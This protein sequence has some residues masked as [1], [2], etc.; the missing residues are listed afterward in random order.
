MIL[1][2]TARRF[3]SWLL[4]VALNLAVVAASASYAAAAD[5]SANGTRLWDFRYPNR[6]AAHEMTM[7]D[8]VMLSD[9]S[10]AI[11]AMGD[12]W[13]GSLGLYRLGPDGGFRGRQEL[14]G[15]RGW[16]T[17][18][19]MPAIALVDGVGGSPGYIVVGSH[20]GYGRL[21]LGS[22]P[23]ADF[24][25][26]ESP[27]DAVV[28]VAASD[29]G[30]VW[31]GGGD[32]DETRYPSNCARAVIVKFGA[33]E[34]QEWRW[35]FEGHDDSAFVR[36]IVHISHGAVL[37]KIST[38][39]LRG[40]GSNEWSLSCGEWSGQEW[41]VWIAADGRTQQ[42]VDLDSDEVETLAVLPGGRIAI[43]SLAENVY[44]S[45]QLRLRVLS[46]DGAQTLIDRRYSL[47]QRRGPNP[48][49]PAARLPFGW[50]VSAV[51]KLGV[52]P[53]G[54]YMGVTFDCWNCR[55]WRTHMLRLDWNGEIKAVSS[56]WP[57]QARFLMG[58]ESDA[59]EYIVGGSNG[60]FRL[61]LP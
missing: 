57:G 48:R 21:P 31:I 17:E 41:L 32:Q 39:G 24:A 12:E 25:W 53:D 10:M 18:Q 40:N 26:K 6:V 8:G 38:D 61:P 15:W 3:F 45:R 14:F 54:L 16:H 35:V 56:A 58:I 37:A 42:V 60:V 52:L 27:F 47:D 22:L 19:P 13:R 30:S 36:G 50:E 23:V 49:A 43:A 4:V 11:L 44:Y 55:Y 20:L 7:T 2:L 1:N 5:D 46:A 28:A 29:D 51:E 34:K 33:D 59:A 9:G